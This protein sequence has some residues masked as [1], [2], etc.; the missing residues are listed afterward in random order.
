[1]VKNY[2]YKK[3]NYNI[4]AFVFAGAHLEIKGKVIIFQKQPPSVFYGKTIEN[5]ENYLWSILHF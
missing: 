3:G 4:K 2:F 5:S 1:M